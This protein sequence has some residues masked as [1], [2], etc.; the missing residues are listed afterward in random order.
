LGGALIRSVTRLGAL[1]LVGVLSYSPEKAGRD[2]GDVLG[3]D[4]TGV[5]ITT[6]RAELI[7]A[8]PDVVLHAPLDVGG[9][10]ADDDII[11][12]LSAG[13]NVITA[14]PYRMLRWREKQAIDRLHAAAERGGATFFVTG[15]NPEFVAERLVLTLSGLCAEVDHISVKEIWR[16]DTIGSLMF[17]VVGFGKPL[18]Q[19]L[20]ELVLELSTPYFEPSMRIAAEA[21]GRPLDRV[22]RSH[23]NTAAE[24]DIDLP[25]TTIRAGTISRLA[26]KWA[27]YCGDDLFYSLEGIYYVGEDLRPPEA[28]ADECWII[29][30]EGR[31]SVRIA[32]DSLASIRTGERYYDR[33]PTQPGYYATAVPLIQAVPAVVTAPPGVMENPLP[34]F[35]YSADLLKASVAAGHGR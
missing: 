2:V 22:E 30:I 14:H 10:S 1:E 35:H 26:M 29:E 16:G 18:E 13:I 25:T 21:M 7:A 12:L 33:D 5:N 31:P 32:V 34:A 4:A 3:M 9:F 6:D 27:G 23:R 20:S 15:I 11:E 28:V 24:H 17:D 8:R 19:S